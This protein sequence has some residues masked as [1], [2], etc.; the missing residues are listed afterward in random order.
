MS[1]GPVCYTD[2]WRISRKP[3][4]CC[5]CGGIIFYKERYNYFSGIWDGEANSY[6]TC[7]DCCDIRDAIRSTCS[8][9]EA[10]CFGELYSYIGEYG[11]KEYLT[12]LE[13]WVDVCDKRGVKVRP[14]YRE[15]LRKHTKRSK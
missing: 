2:K 5:E 12:Y 1:E 15:E 14:E 7:Q 4:R 8:Y 11:Y 3:H 6:K 9:D 10:P 13:K